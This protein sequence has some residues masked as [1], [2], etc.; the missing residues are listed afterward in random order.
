MQRVCMM[1]CVLGLLSL[2]LGCPAG[3]NFVR[4]E[5]GSH[6]GV[7]NDNN[8]LTLVNMGEGRVA[9]ESNTPAE[10]AYGALLENL[11][12]LKASLNYQPEEFN[13]SQ[14]DN[15]FQVWVDSQGVKK[16][17][18]YEEKVYSSLN[19]DV[20]ALS[21]LK[22]VVDNL[23]SAGTHVV[24]WTI[25]MKL[26]DNLKS[27]AEYISEVIN[28]K[29]SILSRDNL[30][31][32]RASNNVV[33]MQDFK[34][35]L[36]LMLSIRNNLIERVKIMLRGA[37]GLAT[38]K[39]LAR[40]NIRALILHLDKIIEEDGFLYKSIFSTCK[41]ILGLRGL[42]DLMRIRVNKLGH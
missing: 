15:I 9:R 5:R 32:L 22:I 16:E 31:A 2:M 30:L 33:D 36:D 41:P 11:N 23:A 34:Y 4:E 38:M 39:V 10:Q 18:E 24:D 42:R 6:S 12:K 3:S 26:L 1:I 14:F 7:R 27:S 29:G 20:E 21:N 19:R 40:A 35:I 13:R 28:D 17:R 25:A 8:L 37:A